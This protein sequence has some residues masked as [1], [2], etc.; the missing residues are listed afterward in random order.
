MAIPSQLLALA[1][2]LSSFPP[3]AFG[4]L[5]EENAYQASAKGE[6]AVVI[7]DAKMA[8]GALV[9]T[10]D[11]LLDGLL[12]D[13]QTLTRE[14]N[15]VAECDAYLWYLQDLPRRYALRYDAHFAGRFLVTTTAMSNR[16]TDGNFQQLTCAAEEL[17]LRLLVKQAT[18][19]LELWGLLSEGV[20]TALDAFVDNVSSH[21]NPRRLHENSLERMNVHP[22]AE[23]S[24]GAPTELKEWFTPLNK[25]EYVHPFAADESEG[26][27]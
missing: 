17:A 11:I 24:G 27:P 15:T 20:S 9:Y 22:E 25:G 21:L 14:D 5:D 26:T 16:F 1:D 2:E 18:V 12:E 3:S 6:S 10:T 13:F 8:A 19:V 7:E 23:D 4:A